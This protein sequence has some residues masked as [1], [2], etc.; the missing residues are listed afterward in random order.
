M[1]KCKIKTMEKFSH[2][3]FFKATDLHLKTLN[4]MVIERTE[5]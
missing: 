3:L 1:L 2:T 4:D 5:H